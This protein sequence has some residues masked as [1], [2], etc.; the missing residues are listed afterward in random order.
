[1]KKLRKRTFSIMPQSCFHRQTYK[2]IKW[3][4]HFRISMSSP[5]PPICQYTNQYIVLND[6]YIIYLWYYAS[7]QWFFSCVA[8]MTNG[9]QWMTFFFFL[10]NQQFIGFCPSTQ[11]Y[12]VVCVFAMWLSTKEF[13][14]G[15]EWHYHNHALTKKNS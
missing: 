6:S 5:I 3:G 9:V 1:M 12:V 11:W 10:P 4:H 2:H 15:I 13:T 8:M 7:I 14:Q